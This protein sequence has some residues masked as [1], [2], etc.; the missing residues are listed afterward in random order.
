M[1]LLIL[2]SREALAGSAP[3]IAGV[4]AGEN[5][6]E[7]SLDGGSTTRQ[8]ALLEMKPYEDGITTALSRV[9]WAGPAG[10]TTAVAARYDKQVDRSYS[11]FQLIEMP[12]QKPLGSPRYVDDLSGIARRDFSFLHP[13]S[14]KGLAIDPW[15]IDDG[16]RLGIKHSLVHINL[17]EVID[18]SQRPSQETWV[19]DGTSVPINMDTI[20]RI[21]Y[22]CQKLTE[23]GVNLTGIL[24]NF[25]PAKPDPHN[26]LIHPRTRLSET[27]FHL[28]AINTTDDRGLLYYR[29]AVEYVANRYSDPEAT[30]GW[31]SGY[32]VGNEVQSHS[33]WYN[34]GE[35]AL[36][37]FVK[38]Y[39]I[40]VRVA[41]LACRRYH[42][43]LRVFVCM[44][45]NWNVST[46]PE[47]PG[48]F[49]A[50]RDFLEQFA[51]WGR[52]G[53]DFPWNVAIHPYPENLAKPWF[54]C[55]QRATASFDTPKITFR[56]MEV[57]PAFLKQSHMLY[58]GQPRRIVLNEQGFNCLSDRSDGEL[59]QAAAYA[60]SYYRLSHIPTI[61]S[62]ILHRHVDDSRKDVG[63]PFS[64]GIWTA[65]QNNT[66]S[67]R[68]PD[69]KRLIYDVVRLADTGTWR[70]AFEFAKPVIGIR[71]WDEMLPVSEAAIEK[72]PDRTPYLT[73][74][75]AGRSPYAIV[76]Q[77][78]E[79]AATGVAAQHLQR[80]LEEMSGVRLPIVSKDAG[81]K[82]PALLLGALEPGKDGILLRTTGTNVVLS[83][84]TDADM[85]C[86]VSVFLQR[87]LGVVWLSDDSNFVPRRQLVTLPEID[88]AYAPPFAYR[89]VVSS[90]DR[91]QQASPWDRLTSAPA[92]GA[93]VILGPGLT[94]AELAARVKALAGTGVRALTIKMDANTFVGEPP[95]LAQYLASQLMWDPRRD[96]A[97]VRVEFYSAWYGS[98][99]D[100]VLDYTAVLARLPEEERAR[101]LGAGSAN[102]IVDPSLLS[103]GLGILTQARILQTSAATVRKIDRLLLPLWCIQL[104]APQKYG[105][106]DDD[107]GM[108]LGEVK[109]VMRENPDLYAGETGRRRARWLAKMEATQRRLKSVG[110]VDL[111]LHMGE[112]ETQN[113][114]PGTW[115]PRTAEIGGRTVRTVF[116]HPP[117]EGFGDATYRIQLPAIAVNQR[118]TLSFATLLTANSLDGVCFSVLADG[119]TI[120]TSTQRD[121]LPFDH[122]VDLRAW[123]GQT[124][125]LTLRVEALENAVRDHANWVKPQVR[126]ED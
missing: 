53:G 13:T 110:V 77:R 78:A 51:Q 10:T 81:W 80:V 39:G 56:N 42:D 97:T 58:R 25:V 114:R 104:N 47:Q 5:T 67:T 21:D 48:G 123:A 73:L 103:E 125:R 27:P 98:A 20:R 122:K 59:V 71:S 4:K 93:T 14:I 28:G 63:D 43:R 41:D 34:M 46:A 102:A 64:F 38:D 44:D 31:I 55:D 45:H 126:V 84:S 2:Q 30:H 26:P 79:S 62:Y 65:Q 15:M 32:I 100:Q 117:D 99:A 19:V 106:G 95:A 9:V 108:V 74:I 70:A 7:I 101:V 115:E 88:H 8:L 116:Q 66:Q 57:L 118:L 24:N 107:A 49:F 72:T 124:I 83:A 113:L 85:L 91:L 94:A 1:F 111:Y 82:G 87:Y 3:S 120:W 105:L 96:P 61:D 17:N 22:S 52:S 54:W 35:T 76:V 29:A 86:C 18:T 50:G 119:R 40:A 37:D 16:I 23:A 33:V 69:R 112:A 68:A 121:V 60:C 90:N 109:R 12:S 92:A 36:R 89:Q 11:K 6:L 75:D